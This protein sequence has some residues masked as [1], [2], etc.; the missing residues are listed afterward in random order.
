MD[1]ASAFGAGDFR[2]ESWAGQK[3]VAEVKWMLLCAQGTSWAVVVTQAFLGVGS[4]PG[5]AAA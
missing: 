5:L 3:L 2:F 1:K 4:I